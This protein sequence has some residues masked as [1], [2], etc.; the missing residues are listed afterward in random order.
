MIFKFFRFCLTLSVTEK[1]KN[2]IFEM[3]IITQTLNINNL[4]TTSAK[5][6]NVDSIRKL[7]EYCLINLVA[8]AM[9]FFIV[10]EILL[11][12]GRSVL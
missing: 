10:L 6:I 5:S 4:R 9:L 2:S 8:R 7:V 12:G 11:S 1:L 3:P